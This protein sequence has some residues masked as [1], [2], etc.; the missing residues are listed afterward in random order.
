MT[1]SG[2]ITAALVFV[3]LFFIVGGFSVTGRCLRLLEASGTENYQ[4]SVK[5]FGYYDPIL[6]GWSL[7]VRGHGWWFTLV[8]FVWLVILL[9]RY[10][11]RDAA[12][13]AAYSG[14]RFPIAVTLLLATAF[15]LSG[16]QALRM[17]LEGWSS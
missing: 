15:A 16:V 17:T 12:V 6:T 13:T 10:R 8:P 11:R 1:S 3:Q 5:H 4:D 9:V 14:L 7:F 2:K